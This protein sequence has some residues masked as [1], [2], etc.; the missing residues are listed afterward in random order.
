[1]KLSYLFD[2][3]VNIEYT[4]VENSA[5]YALERIGDTLYIYFESSNGV[6]DWL[7]NFDFPAKPYKRMGKTVWFAH[8]GFL[9]VWKSVERHAASALLDRTVRKIVVVGYSH[10]A[11]VAAFC[12]EYIWFNRPELR[13]RLEGYGFG[14]P[15]IFWGIQTKSIKRRWENFTVVRNI[16][17]IV[18]HL[19]PAVFGFSHVGKLLKI[20]KRKKYSSVDAHRPNNIAEE[21]KIYESKETTEQE[22]ARSALSCHPFLK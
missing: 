21:L 8:R 7:N 5:D 11:A 17:D 18:T 2:R 19:P 1:M 16:N 9:K 12:H 13:D 14:C 3:C 15:R 6:T 10:G 4:H 20:G 22:A